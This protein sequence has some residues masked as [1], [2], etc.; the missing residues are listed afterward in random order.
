M[1]TTGIRI[2]H[3]ERV[4]P[5]FKY[6]WLILFVFTGYLKA[7]VLRLIYG[8]LTFQSFSIQISVIPWF[9][10]ASQSCLRLFSRSIVEPR[11]SRTSRT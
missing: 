4:F 10:D 11:I 8:L 3:D 5:I 6:N 7:Q 2:F 1:L 9:G